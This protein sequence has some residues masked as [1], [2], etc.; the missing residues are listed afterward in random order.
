MT[1]AAARH[2][3]AHIPLQDADRPL[4]I[5]RYAEHALDT[6]G[7]GDRPSRLNLVASFAPP[8]SPRGPNEQLEAALRVWASHARSELARTVP[9]TEVLRD[10]ANQSR[11]L[12]AVS[13]RLVAASFALGHLPENEAELVH[14]ELR[15]AAQV[16]HR[17]QQQW[18][19]VT[20][21]SRPTHEYVTATT[22]MHA[23][24][25]AIEGESLLPSAQVDAAK[26]IDVGLALADLRYAATDLVGLTN[27]AALLPEPLIR[28]GLLFAPARILPSTMER[29]H[30]RNHGRYVAIQLSEGAELI[31]AA[32][33]GPRAARH[34]QEALEAAARPAA[35]TELSVQTLA[36]GYSRR[37][38]EPASELRGPHLF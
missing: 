21:A 31:D 30:D 32:Q 18:E 27:T 4:A 25:S 6:I 20:T 24:L 11:H 12:Y 3:L 16:M 33:Q 17:L 28:S 34:A 13:T 35:A 26:R 36:E 23:S 22:A 14:V 2:G 10:I 29:L 7:D 38:L 8:S 9:S 15:D 37:K 5:A 1:I 19:T